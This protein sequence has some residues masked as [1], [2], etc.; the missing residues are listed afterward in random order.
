MRAAVADDRGARMIDMKADGMT[1]R[2]IAEDFGISVD[3]VRELMARAQSRTRMER[4]EPNRA[5]LSVRAANAV[6]F[7][8][9]EPEQDPGERDALLPS[10][11]A[12]LTRTQMLGVSNAGRRTIAEI[13]AWLWDRGL[14]FSEAD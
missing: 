8:I 10:R 6:R 4:T 3:R 1:L 12:A 11:V 7:L 5:A 14:G 9:D 13:E 2:Q